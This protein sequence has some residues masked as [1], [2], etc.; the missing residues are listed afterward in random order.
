MR[1]SEGG[2]ARHTIP[3]CY[4]FENEYT[5]RQE[6]KLN[7]FK[8][9]LKYLTH[10]ATKELPTKVKSMNLYEKKNKTKKPGYLK[11]V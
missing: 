6:F 11:V 7:Y 8:A 5:T 4:E 3:M 9:T 2:G 1:V 10:F